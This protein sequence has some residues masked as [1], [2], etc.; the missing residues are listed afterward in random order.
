MIPEKK[1]ETVIVLEGQLPSIE[2]QF[3]VSV[4]RS[5]IP[6]G[7]KTG[8]IKLTTSKISEVFSWGS[9]R[10]G[11]LDTVV[12]GFVLPRYDPGIFQ[13]RLVDVTEQITNI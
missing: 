13:A 11:N 8:F 7:L 5:H 12:D 3:K 4:E 6:F 2:N 9:E 10:D 1:S